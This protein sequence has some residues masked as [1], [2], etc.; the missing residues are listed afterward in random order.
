[1]RS[2]KRPILFTS[3]PTISSQFSWAFLFFPWAE[4]LP[5]IHSWSY[6]S[7]HQTSEDKKRLRTGTWLNDPYIQLDHQINIRLGRTRAFDVRCTRASENHPHL[8]SIW[9]FRGRRKREKEKKGELIFE[10]QTFW[11]LFLLFSLVVIITRRV[12]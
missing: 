12:F 2:P 10:F 8:L 11:S 5:E 6:P 3:N 9:H 1:M 4:F 7:C